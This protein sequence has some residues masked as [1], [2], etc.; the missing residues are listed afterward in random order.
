MK[1][2]KRVR[3]KYGPDDWHF[4]DL[5]LPEGGGPH[6]VALVIHGGF[7]RAR[8]GL[9]L[10]DRMCDDLTGRALATWNIE[11]PRVGHDGGGWP[12]TLLDVAK[13]ADYLRVLAPAYNLD[14]ARVAAI[15]H[16]AGG[17]LGLWLAGRHRLPAG[18]ALSVARREPLPLRG[19]VSLAGVCDLELMWQVRQVES[20]VAA[21]LGGT[22]AE[23]PGRYALAS[24]IRLLPLG[25]PQVLAHGTEDENVPLAVSERYREAAA[26]AGDDVQMIT[27]PGVEHFKV[28][29]PR[30]TCGRRSSLRSCGSSAKRNDAQPVDIGTQMWLYI[31]QCH[32]WQ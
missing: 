23:Q 29:D 20:P 19:V 31:K 3:I 22:P 8:Y 5:R 18:G 15:G 32:C 28:I 30:P 10:M 25:V 7:W 2:A 21:F 16:S 12:G 13:A 17:H 11:Y 4:G 27:L 14:L 24:P 9:D 26:A 6:P 1:Q